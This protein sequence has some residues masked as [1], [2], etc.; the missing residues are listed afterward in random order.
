MAFI[1]T[2]LITTLATYLLIDDYDKFVIFIILEG[3]LLSLM[4][5]PI[6]IIWFKKIKEQVKDAL[7]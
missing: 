5:V 3:V 1:F 6:V 7:H 4:S 2:F